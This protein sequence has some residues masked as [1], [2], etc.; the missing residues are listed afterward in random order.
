[1]DEYNNE[2]AAVCGNGIADGL[3]V[4]ADNGD[5]SVLV[6]TVYKVLHL[7]VDSVDLF[8]DQ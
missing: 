6:A 8:G 7:V 5:C 2:K 1:M 3:S 4:M